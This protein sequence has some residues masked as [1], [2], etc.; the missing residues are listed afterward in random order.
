MRGLRARAQGQ[1]PVRRCS[2]CLCVGHTARSCQWQHRGCGAV[3]LGAFGYVPEPE[4]T[5]ES[6]PV[7]PPA[8]VA[9][10]APG[11]AAVHARA[12]MDIADQLRATELLRDVLANR[13]A[14]ELASYDAAIGAPAVRFIEPGDPQ[15]QTSHNGGRRCH[16]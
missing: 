8:P 1:P 2:T 7:L 10:R 6:T 13:L 4:D 11:L 12:I 5:V 16:A 14:I 3:A 15:P 9:P